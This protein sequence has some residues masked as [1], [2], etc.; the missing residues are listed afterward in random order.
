MKKPNLQLFLIMFTLFFTSLGCSS[1]DDMRRN[2]YLPPLNF[3]VNFDLSLPEYNQLNFPGNNFV[4]RNYGLNGIVIYNL[5][6]D[7]Y[8]AYELSDPNH[9]P[10]ACSA[11]I[12]EGI[13]AIC[14]CEDGNRYNIITGEQVAGTGE[15]ALQF[16][17]IVRTGNVLQISN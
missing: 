9:I 6:N 14:S 15:Y 7:Q 2:P 17:R 1:D 12:V 4:T 8:L 16:Y 5:N 13:E 10:Q 3:S 11:L